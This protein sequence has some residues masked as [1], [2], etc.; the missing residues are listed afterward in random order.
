MGS[1]LQ[2]VAKGP[3]LPHLNPPLTKGRKLAEQHIEKNRDEQTLTENLEAP[4]Y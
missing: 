2:L 1:N 3:T 4:Y